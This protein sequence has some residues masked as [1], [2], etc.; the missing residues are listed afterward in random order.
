MKRDYSKRLKWKWREYKE[1]ASFPVTA[2]LWRK[3]GV[4]KHLAATF[5]EICKGLGM[6]PFG[7]EGLHR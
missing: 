1:N 7:C 3:S 6:L 4:C 2:Y 5:L